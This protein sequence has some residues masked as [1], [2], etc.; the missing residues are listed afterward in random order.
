MSEKT[1][2][3]L[4]KARNINEL[5]DVISQ[6]ASS[7]K[8]NSAAAKNLQT[9]LASVSEEELK[10]EHSPAKS[11]KIKIS[12]FTMPSQGAIKKNSELVR[13]LYDNATQ[14]ETAEAMIKNSFNGQKGAKEA[15]TA[16]AK[17][18]ENV[19]QSIAEAF[20]ALND[21]AQKHQPKE[22]EKITNQ[23]VQ[24]IERNFEDASYK[25]ISL[26]VY[27][28]IEN[29]AIQFCNYINIQGLKDTKGFVAEDYFVILTASIPVTGGDPELR[30][31]SIH[32]F[33]PPGKYNPGRLVNGIKGV[34]NE[35]QK[36]LAHDAVHSL[37]DQKPLAVDDE[38]SFTNVKGV[39]DA[40]VE[41]DTLVCVVE[42]NIK[43]LN[44]VIVSV[45][46]LLRAVVGQ[47]NKIR[48]KVKKTAK[49]TKIEF[50]LT[51]GIADKGG[52]NLSK[53]DTLKDLL[54]LDDSEM[55]QIRSALKG[56]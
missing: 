4:R 28:T 37:L 31:T 18:K 43:D 48:H 32:D 23:L 19:E 15:L 29:K 54:E 3:K 25:D 56:K 8:K 35:L 46:S 52:L 10:I 13:S 50:M 9:V 2:E 44:T 51:S 1:L 20:D 21:L 38:K 47:K 39:K 34:T 30:L 12:K 45:I 55:K 22:I 6:I 24:F 17:L 27:V 36:L 49:S 16:L 7:I 14:L 11:G 41:D 5:T 40:Y 42:N 33:R 26:E 53:L